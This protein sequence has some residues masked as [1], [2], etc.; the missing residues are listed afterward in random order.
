MFIIYKDNFAVAMC[1]PETDFILA[2]KIA[3]YFQKQCGCQ[4]GLASPIHYYVQ[5]VL[6]TV[7]QQ[8]I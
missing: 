7:S 8:L 2:K 3:E 4:L 6:D 5:Q 1:P